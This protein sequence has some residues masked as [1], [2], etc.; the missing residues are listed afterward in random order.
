MHLT[1]DASN[2]VRLSQL[3]IT[4]PKDSPNTDGIDVGD[5]KAIQILNSKIGTGMFYLS[6]II[7]ITKYIYISPYDQLLFFLS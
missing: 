2:D 1:I 6:C 5:S 3:T 7:I 4:A